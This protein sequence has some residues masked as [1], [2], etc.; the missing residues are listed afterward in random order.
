MTKLTDEELDDLRE[1]VSRTSAFDYSFSCGE[2]DALLDRIQAQADE[3]E[4]LQAK[5][6][7]LQ[8]EIAGADGRLEAAYQSSLEKDTLNIIDHIHDEVIDHCDTAEECRSEI[9]NYSLN[10][11][12][13]KER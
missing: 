11:S 10:F 1:R 12:G 7:E 6:I 13:G 5:V 2:V 8:Q 4:K 9:V 3:N